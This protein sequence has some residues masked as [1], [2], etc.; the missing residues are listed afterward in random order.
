MAVYAVSD[1]HGVYEIWNQIKHFLKEDDTLYILGDCGDR[2]R[3][4]WRIIKEVARDKRTIH[5]KGNHEDMLVKAMTEWLDDY[6]NGNAH[7][8]LVSNG[9]YDT[10]N[11]WWCDEDPRYHRGW[12]DYLESL[13]QFMIYENAKGQKVHLCHAGY[14]PSEAPE[15]QIYNVFERKHWANDLLWDREHYFHVWPEEDEYKDIIVV[16]GHTPTPYI[17][18]DLGYRSEEFELGA[19]WY[20]D[21]HK[22]CI[23]N[24]T[25]ATGIITLI[26]LDTWEQLI[27]STDK[28]DN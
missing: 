17:A 26:N 21:G 10:I 14:T 12:R 19:F 24:A 28:E 1:I 9:G 22:V 11:D 13:P 27:F 3:D 8:L 25:F 7:H 5:L 20:A 18:E 6:M 2:G 16:H 15:P 23:D 4:G